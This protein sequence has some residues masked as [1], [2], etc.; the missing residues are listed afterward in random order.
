MVARYD[1]PSLLVVPNAGWSR[2]DYLPTTNASRRK[3]S[4]RRVSEYG[5]VDIQPGAMWR[6]IIE[7]RQPAS[8][9][10]VAV[11]LGAKVRSPLYVPLSAGRHTIAVRCSDAWSDDLPFYWE[12]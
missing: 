7:L 8:G 5:P 4:P 12:N 10:S 6:G 3:Y 9:Q 11:A 1:C 2:H